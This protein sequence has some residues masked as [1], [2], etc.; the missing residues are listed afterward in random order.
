MLTTDQ[1]FT[2][3]PEETA[4][5]LNGINVRH[6]E[7]RVW[8]PVH[9][10]G[11]PDDNNPDDGFGGFIYHLQTVTYYYITE[12]GQPPK[13]DGSNVLEDSA[14]RQIDKEN[15]IGKNWQQTFD[16]IYTKFELPVEKGGCG[17]E[18]KVL[19]RQVHQLEEPDFCLLGQKWNSLYGLQK[20]KDEEEEEMDL[21]GREKKRRH[22]GTCSVHQLAGKSAMDPNDTRR[23]NHKTRYQPYKNRVSKCSRR[24]FFRGR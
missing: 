20:R 11:E 2:D 23:R 15:K 3:A 10:D 5:S 1:H 17:G 18:W 6:K 12:D 21:V 14:A 7:R 13:K 19:E 24:G 22:L 9:E 8:F 16:L 4:P